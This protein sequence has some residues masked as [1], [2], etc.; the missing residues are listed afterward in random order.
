MA[1]LPQ[2]KTVLAQ[3]MLEDL[4]LRNYSPHTIRCY[5]RCVAEFAQHFQTSPAR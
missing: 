1:T 2:P 3:R 4:Q 5:L